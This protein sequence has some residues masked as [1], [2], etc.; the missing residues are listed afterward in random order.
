M[1]YDLQTWTNGQPGGTPLSATR[2]QHIEDGLAALDALK[3]DQV[4]VDSN[5]AAKAPLV[6]THL[7]ADLG[8][9]SSIGRLLLHADD[10]PTARTLIG[11]GTSSLGL[12]TAS[13]DAA[14]G[15][16][17]HTSA[18]VTDLTATIN[19]RVS[20]QLAAGSN[21]SLTVDPVTSVVTVNASAPGSS[22]TLANLPAGTTLTVLKDPTTGW[23]S[24][25]TARADLIVQWKG[26]DPSP[27]IVS[28]GTGGMLNNVDVRFVTS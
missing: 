2:L 18:G 21:V 10:A 26:A 1:S 9:A 19:A 24:R 8:D 6:H 15:N 20:A 7:V 13:T 16:H 4:Y 25:P 27:S 12:G 22:P 14:P 28:S 5:L 11:A 3:V 17:T 23:P